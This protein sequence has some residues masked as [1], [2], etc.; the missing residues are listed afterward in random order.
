L[1]DR[2]VL[3]SALASKT[4]AEQSEFIR[5]ALRDELS[6]DGIALLKKRARFGPL[7]ELFPHEATNWAAQAG[8]EVT[9]CVAFRLDRPDGLRA[10]VVL[11]TQSAIRNPQSATEY[12]LLRVNNVTPLATL[13]HATS[14][15]PL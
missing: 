15:S 5:K 1:L 12:R 6:P 4:P 11:V 2:L 7:L 3:P 14:N 13:H 9:N 10:E 8:V